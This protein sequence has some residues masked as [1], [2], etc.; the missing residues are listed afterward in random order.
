MRKAF[1]DASFKQSRSQLDLE[2][3]E[4]KEERGPS[5]DRD[6]TDIFFTILIIFGWIAM[7]VIGLIVLGPIHS[8]T[9]N[10]GDPERLLRG[11][12][13]EGN[14]CGVDN[15]VKDLGKK[16]EP[17]WNFITKSST[18]DLVASELG[19]CV[20][21]C[22]ES[23][24]TRSDP[25]GKYGNWT[26]SSD[27]TNILE[28]C[29]PVDITAASSFFTDTFGDVIR[30]IGAIGLFGI[31]LTIV[32]SYLYL[33]FLRIPCMLNF[34]IWG[35]CFLV[36]ALLAGLGAMFLIKA[37]S[38]ESQ[39][40]SDALNDDQITALNVAGWVLIGLAFVWL[41]V[42]LFMRERIMLAI[43]L[44]QEAAACITALVMLPLLLLLQVVLFIGF[45]AIWLWYTVY[46]VSSADIITK[47]DSTTGS[48]YKEL[49]YTD[50]SKQAIF[51]MFFIWLWTTA[52]IQ[53]LGQISQAHA[54][55]I[56]YFLPDRGALPLSQVFLS[57][58][59]MSRY[60]WGTAACGSLILA[61]LNFIRGVLTYL[62]YKLGEKDGIFSKFVLKCLFCCL[63][64]LEKFIK[65][66]NKHA[67]IQC[68]FDGK[69]FLASA[70]RSFGLISRNLGRVATV[71]VVSNITINVGKFAI[72]LS[73]MILGYLY[74]VHVKELAGYI[75]PTIFVGLIAYFAASVFL[76]VI[77]T[78]ADTLLQG[79]LIEEEIE[80]NQRAGR[81]RG[82]KQ[83]SKHS[84]SMRATL[85][86]SK[87]LKHTLKA[88]GD[89]P[90]IQGENPNFKGKQDDGEDH[91]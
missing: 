44:V 84:K 67:Y 23:G 86:K 82:L 54:S 74:L 76:E 71:S 41:C 70:M 60:H 88:I 4:I 77:G 27:T 45:T 52:F 29:I 83:K 17:N 58:G 31:A 68:A 24:E 20:S 6:C 66:I 12:D 79:F 15:P 32:L 14:I 53:A 59:E 80:R 73:A 10:K 65:F 75:L 81:G 22:P 33:F 63:W 9:I 72:M 34:M 39:E 19:I 69:G 87:S 42:V 36:E 26:S 85:N 18:G 47:Y 91:L 30:S 56:W 57:L 7:T 16:W 37:R 64:C 1:R 50:R 38:E 21:S 90:N 2:F 78:T 8:T 43:T 35:S 40:G 5:K 49:E 13:Y 62:K 46:L 25:Y 11:V 48:S 89:D 55:L 3:T 61:V 51:F 28:Y